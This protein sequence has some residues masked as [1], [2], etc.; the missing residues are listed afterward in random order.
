MPTYQYQCTECGEGLEAVQKFTD[1]A[2]TE[3]PACEG[4]LRK[5][6]SAVGVVFKGSGFYRTDSRGASSSS[7]STSSSSKAK[8]DSG[9]SSTGSGSGSGSGSSSGST[10]SSAAS[11][12][13]G[14]AGSSAA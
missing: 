12:S 7:S 2:L 10:S 9:S 4:R 6:F 1:E 14:S 13:G 5:V 8:S 3:C 11:S